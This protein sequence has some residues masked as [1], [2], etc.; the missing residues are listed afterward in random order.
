MLKAGFHKVCITPPVGVPLAG[1]AARQDVCT[2]IHDDLFV[3]ALVIEANSSTVAIASIDVLAIPGEFV[4]RVRQSV[5]ARVPI[6][7]GNIM[8]A[9][10]HTHAAPVTISTFFNPDESVDP[11]YMERLA[12]ATEDA[13]AGAWE[14]RFPCRIGR[15]SG[16]V[17]RI[18]VNRR[19][20]Q[21]GLVDKEAG[22]VKV[23]DLA[24]KTLGVLVNYACHPTVLG[25]D[26]L[27]V[28]GDFP[29]MAIARIEDALGAGSF[30]MYTNGAQGD[31]SMGHSSELSAIGVIAPGR[32]FEHATELGCRLADA[33]LAVVDRIDSRDSMAVN[34]CQ[35]PVSLP[36]KRYPSPEETARSLVQAANHL[37]ELEARGEASAEYRQAKSELLYCSIDDFYARETARLA[38]GRLPIDLQGIRIHDSIFVGIPGELFV[39]VALAARQAARNPI[40][41]VGLANGY[42]GYLPCPEAYEA[43]GYEIVSA[44]CAPDFA[45][46]LLHGIL[47][48]EQRLMP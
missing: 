9:C 42:I 43:G 30:A 38:D 46:R 12:Q 21:D 25:P 34:A 32:T 5:A 39:E 10:T 15:G 11:R 40:F 17:E 24:G 47:Q 2:G 29:N 20:P 28:T 4:G 6:P 35:V 18:A 48:L 37:K 22:I 33:V 14:Q 23:A 31:L 27:L 16:H 13:V 45:D 19:D 1:F 3:R 8:V 26:N 7:A 44:K 41:A 36:L